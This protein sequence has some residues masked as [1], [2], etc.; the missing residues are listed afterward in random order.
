MKKIEIPLSKTKLVLRGVGAIVFAILGVWIFVSADQNAQY[1]PL[2]ARAIGTLTFLVF[3]ISTFLIIKKMFKKEI[4]LAIDNE[5]ILDNTSS[6]S[7]GLIRWQDVQKTEVIS[8]NSVK[9]LLIYVSNPD[10][11]IR[12]N[13]AQ[14]LMLSQIYSMQ[15][16]PICISSKSI[17]CSFKNMQKLIE[18]AINNYQNNLNI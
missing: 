2:V 3:G 11:Y 10:F 9:F 7:V 4:G 5:G 13:K 15:N 18:D 16:T 12:G 14:K 6:S 17:Q 8:I 1:D